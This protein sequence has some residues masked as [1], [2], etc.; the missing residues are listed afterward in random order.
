MRRIE[1]P[2]FGVEAVLASMDA[3]PEVALAV[4]GAPVLAG[5]EAIYETVGHAGQ[6][7]RMPTVLREL[8]VVTQAAVKWTYSNRLVRTKSSRKFYDVLKELVGEFDCP[9]CLRREVDELDHYLPKSKFHHLAVTPLNLVPICSRCNKK[10]TDF[11]ATTEQEQPLHPYFDDLGD[12]DWLIASLDERHGVTTF[13]IA[14]SPRWSAVLVAR[15]EAHFDRHGLA[16]LY[17]KQST[18]L[19]GGLRLRL[20]QRLAFG[21]VDAVRSSLLDL[22]RS[23]ENGGFEPWNVAAL[24]AWSASDWFCGGG[25]GPLVLSA[26]DLPSASEP[27]S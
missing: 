15:V 3:S 19:L 24:R 18:R 14:P 9:Y 5:V 25:F 16:N 4:A 23:W 27:I 12:Y 10:K 8:D 1:R 7:Y 21:G 26:D 22:A 17:A 6:L 2:R 20:T 13:S 11:V